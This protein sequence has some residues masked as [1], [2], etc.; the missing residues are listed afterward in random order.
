MSKQSLREEGI[1]ITRKVVPAS[2]LK[3]SQSEL[4][5]PAVA[6]MIEDMLSGAFSQEAADAPIFVTKDGY[7]LDGHHRW[8]AK[9]GIDTMDGKLG[10]VPMT[11]DM[12]DIEIGEA[13]D[14]ARAYAAKRGVVPKKEVHIKPLKKSHP[15]IIEDKLRRVRDAE[16]WGAPV[17]TPLDLDDEFAK[18]LGEDLDSLEALRSRVRADLEAESA[19]RGMSQVRANRVITVSTEQDR[20]AAPIE[21]FVAYAREAGAAGRIFVATASSAPNKQHP[22]GAEVLAA[23]AEAAGA[24]R[25]AGEGEL[26]VSVRGLPGARRGWALPGATFLDYGAAFGH[27]AHATK[28]AREV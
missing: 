25:I 8:A 22:N 18:D 15:V 6:L 10:D 28:L 23:I 5:G 24:S 14:R 26:P 7:V 9:V 17:G 13:I 12:I 1:S 4:V 16:Y 21:A 27:D 11:V 2:N 19:R 20:K 3:A